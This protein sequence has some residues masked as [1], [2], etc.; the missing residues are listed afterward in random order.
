MHRAWVAFAKDGDPQWPGYERSHRATM[1]FDAT[2]QVVDD[3][4]SR[5]RALWEGVR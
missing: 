2:S 4:R 5:E 3:P 1:R